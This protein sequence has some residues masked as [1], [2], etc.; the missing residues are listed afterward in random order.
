MHTHRHINENK[1]KLKIFKGSPIWNGSLSL[2][3]RESRNHERRL[4]PH[5]VLPAILGSPVVPT[6]PADKDV[7]LVA[8]ASRINCPL[9]VV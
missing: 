8:I 9:C 5:V 4:K 1:M 6:A 2:L 3:E 7:M